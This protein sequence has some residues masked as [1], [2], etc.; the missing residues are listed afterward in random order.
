MNV[1]EKIG[2]YEIIEKLG[3]GGMATVYKAYQPTLDRYVAVK[4]LHPALKEDG[5]FRDRFER[6]AKL[7]ARLRH[8]NI[9]AVYDYNTEGENPYLVMDFIEGDTLKAR[10]KEGSLG[11]AM[12]THI[13]SSIGSAL[14]YA[15][16]Q[17][18][19]HRDI[20]PSNIMIDHAGQV[21]L[22]D[23]GLARMAQASE[24]TLSRDMMLGT[25]QYISPEQAM[26]D[27]NLDARTDI[28][29]MGVVIYELVVGRV[30]YSAD[31]P[32]AIVH[33]HIYTPLPLP[34]LVNPQVPEQI[35]AFLLKALAKD[36][37]DR[38]GTI[39][40]SVMA[41]QTAVE[42][43]GDSK[44]V[45]AT[46]AQLRSQDEVRK[47]QEET[48]PGPPSSRPGSTVL[49]KAPSD[50]DSQ[51][52]K[53]TVTRRV[54]RPDSRRSAFWPVIAL[55][56]LF[57]ILLGGGIFVGQVVAEEFSR[58]YQ[59]TQIDSRLFPPPIVERL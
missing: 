50:S 35:E 59:E 1:G 46:K 37:R 12:I 51:P 23:F 24:S 22:T 40:E 53:R 28:Y 58:A 34:T 39:K 38:Y 44:F 29:S 17:G 15:H 32:Y 30:P 25:P 16:A 10:L 21:F 7:V 31:T 57:I 48:R 36:R 13:V 6:E 45:K 20:K 14:E 55:V 9:M 56:L 27:H 2:S 42:Q 43:A 4:V 52:V 47:I 19:L 49:S 33:D 11:I 3:Q 5:N 26:G 54:I 8:Q 41:F 18:L